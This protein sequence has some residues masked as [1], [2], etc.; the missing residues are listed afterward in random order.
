MLKCGK[1]CR[2]YTMHNLKLLL[3]WFVSYFFLFVLNVCVWEWLSAFI[4][5]FWSYGWF[6][7][8]EMSFPTGGTSPS[9]SILAKLSEQR[10]FVKHWHAMNVKFKICLRTTVGQKIYK[11]CACLQRI[12]LRFMC[13][14]FVCIYSVCTKSNK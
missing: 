12:K 4:H 11:S 6:K 5:N 2:K 8:F 9:S 1:I 13:I 3:W 7:S 14:H 10:A